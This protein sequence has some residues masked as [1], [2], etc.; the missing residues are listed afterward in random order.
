MPCILQDLFENHKVLEQV[1]CIGCS[2]CVNT[3]PKGVL[4]LEKFRGNNFDRS[5]I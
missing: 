5:I 3:C 4:Y 2:L 1:Q